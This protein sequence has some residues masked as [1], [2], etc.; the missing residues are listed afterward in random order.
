MTN[1]LNAHES[2]IYPTINQKFDKIQEPYPPETY[3][4]ELNN[5]KSFNFENISYQKELIDDCFPFKSFAISNE[6][7]N[8]SFEEPFYCDASNENF[9]IDQCPKPKFTISK[10][11]KKTGRKRNLKK[12]CS[13]DKIKERQKKIHGKL[14]LDNI[15]TKMQIHFINFIINL[16]NDVIKLNCKDNNL[17][18]KSVN[19]RF[20][21]RIAFNH[22]NNLKKGPIKR[23][24]EEKI[25]NKYKKSEA[26][27]NII[28][29][30]KIINESEWLNKFFNMNYVI[31]FSKYHNNCK[32]LKKI[33]FE[34]K[35]IKLSHKTKSFF[36][37]LRKNKQIKDEIIMIAQ[38]AYFDGR[39]NRK[40]N[41]FVI[42]NDEI[43]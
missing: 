36:D 29:L 34:G 31:L 2:I 19:H 10:E 40:E 17:T 33:V 27:H 1:S 25:S 26:N 41:T 5:P 32:P 9:V 8:D 30:N 38:K 35:E 21:S 12:N 43:K 42:N 20:K 4:F 24:L 23:I 18:F 16:C 22:F 3:D 11:N 39:Q 7:L 13:F 6:N 28:I 15:L 14:A 37:L